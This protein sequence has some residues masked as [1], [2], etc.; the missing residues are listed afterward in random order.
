MS[1]D[2]SRH[3]AHDDGKAAGS[4]RRLCG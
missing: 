2:G 4:L 3:I 1:A